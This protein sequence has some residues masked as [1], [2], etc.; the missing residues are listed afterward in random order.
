MD[1]PGPW[2]L[3]VLVRAPRSTPRDRAEARM[4]SE[5][6]W[7]AVSVCMLAV[8]AIDYR[9][10]RR[11]SGGGGGAFFWAATGGRGRR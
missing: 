4:A 9:L 5:P 1:G 2:S 7:L 11:G 3:S 10:R 8:R 6:A